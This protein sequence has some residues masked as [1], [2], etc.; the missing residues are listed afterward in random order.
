MRLWCNS[1]EESQ[2]VKVLR[3]IVEDST[4]YWVD[5]EIVLELY[6]EKF[7]DETLGQGNNTIINYRKQNTTRFSRVDG[8]V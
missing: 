7:W 3:E 4:R 6:D 8:D 2:L 5:E 1:R